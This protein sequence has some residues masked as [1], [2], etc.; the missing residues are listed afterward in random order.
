MIGYNGCNITPAYTEHVLE[1]WEEC[2]PL[3]AF[4][5]LISCAIPDEQYLVEPPLEQI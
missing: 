4:C 5:L 3:R 2:L 1:R